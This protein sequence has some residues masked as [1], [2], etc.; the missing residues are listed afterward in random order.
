M[1]IVTSV[2]S[3]SK[4]D[5]PRVVLFES[6]E[7]DDSGYFNVYDAN[8]E[9]HWCYTFDLTAE[10]GFEFYHFIMHGECCS[11]LE[12]ALATYIPRHSKPS[13]DDFY[14][15]LCA[16][17]EAHGPGEISLPL[18]HGHFGASQFWEQ[19]WIPKKSWEVRVS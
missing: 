1:F 6:S 18:E 4:A 12:T 8:G 7:F 13:L 9:T 11:I 3:G 16:V 17:M 5:R 19:D 10:E 14:D 15:A 2:D